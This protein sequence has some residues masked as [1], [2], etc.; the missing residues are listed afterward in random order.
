MSVPSLETPKRNLCGV[1][2]TSTHNLFASK[3]SATGRFDLTLGVFTQPTGLHQYLENDGLFI[4][5]SVFYVMN[6]AK[7]CKKHYGSMVKPVLEHR[8]L[9]LPC[10]DMSLSPL[11]LAR[12]SVSS[13]RGQKC[14]FQKVRIIKLSWEH[15]HDANNIRRYK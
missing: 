8:F 9:C 13:G 11:I 12:R 4:H 1:V 14:V 7:K 5:L 15:V 2:Q 10:I 6:V 3:P